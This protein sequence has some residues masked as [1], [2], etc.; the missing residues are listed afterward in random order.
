[1]SNHHLFKISLLHLFVSRQ[2][3]NMC[4]TSSV[5]KHKENCLCVSSYIP[6]F[7]AA[8]NS[9]AIPFVYS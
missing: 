4:L 7:H 2:L 6:Q 5:T 3:S 8:A 1:M 9:H